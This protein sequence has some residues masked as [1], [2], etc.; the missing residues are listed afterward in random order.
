M[1]VDA[2]ASYGNSVGQFFSAKGVRCAYAFSE[3]LHFVDTLLYAQGLTFE[4]FY[5]STDLAGNN[6]PL[7]PIFGIVG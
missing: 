6:L 1:S 2:D 3:I 5:V 4:F 7:V